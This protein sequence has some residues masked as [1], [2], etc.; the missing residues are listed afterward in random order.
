MSTNARIGV[1][2]EDG[3]VTS[4]YTHWDGYPS[5]HGPL[6]LEHYATEESLRRLLALGDLSSLAPEIG[7]AHDFDRALDEHPDWV[8]A[9]GRDR[10]EQDVDARTHGADDWPDYGQ[11]YEY[12]FDA[13]RTWYVRAQ[14]DERFEDWTP[15]THATVIDGGALPAAL[16][17]TSA[18]GPMGY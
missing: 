12:L 1:Q 8:N 18:D 17:P 5:H 7:E 6:L 2:N 16:Y 4:V 3:T 13:S 10:G 11:E 14:Y 9:Y 15:L